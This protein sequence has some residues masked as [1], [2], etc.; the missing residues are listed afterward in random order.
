MLALTQALQC[1]GPARAFSSLS[2]LGLPAALPQPLASLFHLPCRCVAKPEKNCCQVD[3]AFVRSHLA[4]VATYETFATQR[5]CR[6][7]LSSI[8]TSQFPVDAIRWSMLKK[9]FK[10]QAD[11]GEYARKRLVLIEAS[12]A[13]LSDND[14]LDLADVFKSQPRTP[15]GEYVFAEMA[16]RNISL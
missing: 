3:R 2:Q 12:I 10:R 8:A 5:I 15:I 13:G 9:R 1:I 16:R 4:K 11:Q 6:S 7:T 14:L